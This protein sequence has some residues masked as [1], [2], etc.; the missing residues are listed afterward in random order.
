VYSGWAGGGE[1]GAGHHGHGGDSA[2]EM[3]TKL[4]V[5]FDPVK[6]AREK[7]GHAVDNAFSLSSDDA[8]PGKPQVERRWV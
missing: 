4:H 8:L 1:A 6:G 5:K 7:A 2:E 3:R